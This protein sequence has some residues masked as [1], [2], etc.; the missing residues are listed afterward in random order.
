MS[1]R[2]K[3]MEEKL[4]ELQIE[5][6]GERQL[7]QLGAQSTSTAT[8]V[9]DASSEEKKSTKEMTEEE[10]RKEIIDRIMSRLLNT[11]SIK[12]ND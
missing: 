4:K 5:D 10:K 3:E 2:D 9:I 11:K 7:D 6:E 8:P 1:G 12:I